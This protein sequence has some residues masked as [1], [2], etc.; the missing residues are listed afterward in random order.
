VNV[1]KKTITIISDA[2]GAN[3]YA[4]VS[5][6]DVDVIGKKRYKPTI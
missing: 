2:Y 5:I 3:K 1:E 6:K 4:K